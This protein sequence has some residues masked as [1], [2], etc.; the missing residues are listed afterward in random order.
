MV[1]RLIHAIVT[2]FA[3]SIVP[4]TTSPVGQGN[5]SFCGPNVDFM[6]VLFLGFRTAK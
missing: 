4:V 2:I 6:S 3:F 5:I 1:S